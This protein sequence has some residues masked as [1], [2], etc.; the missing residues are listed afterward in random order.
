MQPFKKKEIS[1]VMKSNITKVCIDDFAIKKREKYGSIMVDID[2]HKIVD[3]IE[4][5]DLDAVTKWLKSYPNLEVVS[6]DGS[7]TYKKA[8]TQ[9]HPD[10]IQ[11]SDRFHI[12][13]N[14]TSYCKDFL[15][16]CLGTKVLVDEEVIQLT[17]TDA[18]ILHHKTY[19]MKQ[20]YDLVIQA[21]E[22]GVTKSQ[23]CK[24]YHL[25]IRVFNR[26]N[27][28]SRNERENYYITKCESMQLSK[29][30]NKMKLVKKVR[31]SYKSLH[32]M[33]AVAK[34]FGISKHTVG[35]Y[36]DENFTVTHKS[37]GSTKASIL[38]PYKDII[39][40]HIKIGSTSKVIEQVIRD[41]GYKG[42]GSS[43]RTY[44]AKTKKLITKN[45]TKDGDK[46]L[47]YVERKKL[48]KLLF[49]KVDRVSGLTEEIL[50]K[51]YI[52]EPMFK[53]VIT[54][55]ES[56]RN[57]LKNKE[58]DKLENWINIAESFDI[59]E[60]N[61]FINGI[62]RDI[63]AVKNAIIY[64]YNNGLAEG[65]VNKVKVTKRIMYGRCGFELLRKKSLRLEI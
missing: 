19:T 22:A 38:D 56:F 23:A 9:S 49:Q 40:H 54:L 17:S 5:R 6:R 37:K 43:I 35:K 2:T 16:R 36:L 61:S 47:I 18:T 52:R 21:I 31:E 12:L 27:A 59:S 4:S 33:R 34:M 1:I 46:K 3:M 48:M 15:S 30:A 7:L 65:K 60:I 64:D 45:V 11:V 44:I 28:L 14:L 39:D 29:E 58:V 25:D 53:K 26:L 10:A 50:N 8:I 42:S 13:K 32:S 55:V 63:D 20:K 24:E 57:I 51:A 41:K 62:K